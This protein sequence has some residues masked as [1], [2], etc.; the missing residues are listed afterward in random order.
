MLSRVF[1]I[2]DIK[3]CVFGM[4]FTQTNDMLALR[5]FGDLAN[6]KATT[7]CRHPEDF[8]LFEIGTFDD[9]KGLLENRVPVKLLA[10][11]VE[12]K[13]SGSTLELP[14][15]ASVP[16]AAVNGNDSE[17]SKEVVR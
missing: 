1:S 5:T 7:I 11:A 8:Q 9:S 15:G 4:P 10:S 17:S 12:L 16:A 14:L 6:D 3:S 2:Y 13:R